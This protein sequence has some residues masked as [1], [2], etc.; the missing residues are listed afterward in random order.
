MQKQNEGQLSY[1][2]DGAKINPYT[3]QIAYDSAKTLNKTNQMLTNTFSALDFVQ[4]NKV[5]P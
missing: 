2:I 4:M 5:E 3:I 1:D